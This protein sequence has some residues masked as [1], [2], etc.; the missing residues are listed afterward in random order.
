[1]SKKVLITPDAYAKVALELLENEGY[2]VEFTLPG[3]QMTEEELI[4]KIPGVDGYIAGV[5][6]VTRRVMEHADRLKIIARW[7]VGYDAVDYEAA[8][9]KGIHV[10]T[11][12]GGNHQS[13]A[14]L[15]FALIL[16]VARQLPYYD[17]VVKRG[18]WLRDRVGVEIWSKTIGIFGTGRIGQE[19]AKRAKGFDMT[20]IAY[21]PY[22]NEQWAEQAGVTY[23]SQD[24]L[25]A[26]SDFV[27]LHLPATKETDGMV[28]DDFL[29]KMKPSAYL[30]NTARG[31]LVN[32]QALYKAIKNGVIAGAGLDVFR[33]EPVEKDNPLLTLNG[34]YA[35]HIAA[36]T[37]EAFHG[38][39]V[40]SA[41]EVIRVL[42]GEQPQLLI[43]ELKE[44]NK[45]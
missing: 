30:I 13:V 20:I 8:R 34:V 3:P 14:D 38:M 6:P 42:K 9:E 41:E 29:S 17:Q 37:V 32:E 7:G 4:K 27:S 21:D 35:P 39:S 43:P 33:S 22:K 19:V 25:L 5:N 23:V 26:Q 12:P 40:L 11:T 18:E 31:H 45:N 44:G 28:N 16:G 1:M 36:Y 2:E 24:E 15:A 10:T